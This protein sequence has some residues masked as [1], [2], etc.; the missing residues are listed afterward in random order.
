MLWSE[1][2]KKKKL[3]NKTKKPFLFSN[4]KFNSWTVSM[5][6]YCQNII[7]IKWSRFSHKY[8]ILLLTFRTCLNYSWDKQPLSCW[9]DYKLIQIGGNL[10]IPKFLMYLTLILIIGKNVIL[11]NYEDDIYADMKYHGCTKRKKNQGIELLRTACFHLW[12]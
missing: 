4:V 2:K 5:N 12:L 10:V 7:L 3:K 9:W 8:S 6:K 11:D 1:A